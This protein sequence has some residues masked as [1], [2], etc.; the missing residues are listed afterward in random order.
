MILKKRM[1]EKKREK[2]K[3]PLR[4]SWGRGA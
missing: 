4:R 1:K 2:M 3:K